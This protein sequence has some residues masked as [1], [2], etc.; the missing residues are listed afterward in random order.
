MC[1]TLR[2]GAPQTVPGLTASSWRPADGSGR[3][4]RGSLRESVVVGALE[5][6]DPRSLLD[7]LDARRQD[8]DLGDEAAL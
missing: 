7:G 6:P 2:P 8:A 5:E 1:T 3:V 4:R